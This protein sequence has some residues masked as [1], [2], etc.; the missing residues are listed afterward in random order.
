MYLTEIGLQRQAGGGQCEISRSLQ[1]IRL[2]RL[3]VKEWVLLSGIQN[4]QSQKV[5]PRWRKGRRPQLL[6]S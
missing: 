4:G 2:P 5:A 1:G 3:P 6:P